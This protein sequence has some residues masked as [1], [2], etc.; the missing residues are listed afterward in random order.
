M[1]D[2]SATENKGESIKAR[3]RINLIVTD[4]KTTK[5]TSAIA[6]PVIKRMASGVG[7]AYDTPTSNAMIAEITNAGLLDDVRFWLFIFAQR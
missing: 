3:L 4:S 6:I 2:P 7:I 5:G 1:P